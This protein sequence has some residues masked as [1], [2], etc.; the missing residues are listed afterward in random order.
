M[1][2]PRLFVPGLSQH[3]IHRGNNRCHVF[4]DADDRLRFLSV[5]EKAARDRGVGIHGY[6]LMRTHFHALL[7]PPDA[8]ALPR[9]MQ[10]LGRLY[11]R[12]F[13]DRHRRTGTLW[14]GRYRAGLV[15]DE[16]YWITCL[17][18]IEL[19]PVRAGAVSAPEAYEWSSYRA[20]A[21]GCRDSL[22]TP[23]PLYLQLGPD[24]ASRGVMW[25]RICG[26]PLSEADVAEIRRTTQL[27]EAVG[28][29]PGVPQRSRVA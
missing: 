10:V 1:S 24:A 2:R 26:Q 6:A 21:S 25:S 28:G 5:L 16:R 27:G 4:H 8:Q 20:N 22:L 13:N 9:M 11:V 15:A 14:E 3:V 7:T 29:E 18:Y 17:R 23:H 19:N 12:Y